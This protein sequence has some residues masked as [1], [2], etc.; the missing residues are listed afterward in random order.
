MRT[1]A[2]TGYG[3]TAATVFTLQLTQR[4]GLAN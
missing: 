4:L 1:L 3:L 2:L